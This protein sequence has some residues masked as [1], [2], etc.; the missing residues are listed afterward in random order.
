MIEETSS[1]ITVPASFIFRMLT[2]IYRLR[3][4]DDMSGMDDD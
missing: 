1:T 2:S 3:D 4:S